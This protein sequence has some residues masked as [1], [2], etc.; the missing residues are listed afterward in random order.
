MRSVSKKELF[1]VKK[2]IRTRLDLL[3]TVPVVE[4]LAES[5]KSS[6]ASST[7]RERNGVC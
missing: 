3:R 5:Q 6:S 1:V 2:K 4:V 7:A